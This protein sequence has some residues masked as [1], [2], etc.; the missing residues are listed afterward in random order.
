MGHKVLL[1]ARPHPARQ[2]SIASIVAVESGDREKW[3]S[4]WDENNCCIED[5]VGPS[6]M[7]EK[8]EGHRGMEAVTAFYDNFIS[9]QDVRF[10]IRQTM[11][12]GNECCNVGTITT[13]GAEGNVGRTELVM[14]YKVNEAGKVVSLRAF[15]EFEDMIADAF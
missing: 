11:A 14:I 3:L 5:P 9:P 1:D 15:W 4:L 2:A 13:R 7:D 6:L 12:G 10:H 8:G